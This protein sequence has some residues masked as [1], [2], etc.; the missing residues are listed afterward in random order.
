MVKCS[1]TAAIRRRER[2]RAGEITTRSKADTRGQ[3]GIGNRWY[4][5]GTGNV[6]CVPNAHAYN[7]L[8]VTPNRAGFKIRSTPVHTVAILQIERA[9]RMCELKSRTEIFYP[10]Y[11]GITLIFFK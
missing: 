6:R 7:C 8:D 5:E 9:D 10:L 3:D 2:P 4:R 1:V 11:Y